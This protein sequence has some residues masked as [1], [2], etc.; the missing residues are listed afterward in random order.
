MTTRSSRTT[1]AKLLA[2]LLALTMIAAACGGDDDGDAGTDAGGSDS[3]AADDSVDVD[4]D[5]DDDNEGESVAPTITEPEAEEEAPPDP[6]VGGV[7]RVAMEADGDGLNPAANNF[8]VSAY[9]MGFPMF[10]PLFAYDA[11]GN[12]FP[13]LAESASPVEGTN[14]WQVTLRQGVT[15]HD[16]S[17]MTADDMIAAFEAQLADPIISLAVAPSYPAENRG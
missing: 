10:D 1:L 16:G 4:A 12:W 5:A 11:E 15:Y 2:A 7:L 14:S 6:V 3:G 13:Y 8:A 17:E 9:L